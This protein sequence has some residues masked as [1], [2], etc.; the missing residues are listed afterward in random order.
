MGWN[1]FDGLF[2]TLVVVKLM[3]LIQVYKSIFHC[4]NLV[5]NYK[6]CK[7]LDHQNINY[8]LDQQENIHIL[9]LLGLIWLRRH[10]TRH[11]R[12]HVFSLA[13]VSRCRNSPCNAPPLYVIH[14]RVHSTA[15][16]NHRRA[17]RQ[18]MPG[19]VERAINPIF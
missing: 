6:L 17:L 16:S 12:L 18:Q 19:R 5:H 11:A 15:A 3:L 9:L 10:P 13:L 7:N 8:I 2:L 1:F 14:S 4:L